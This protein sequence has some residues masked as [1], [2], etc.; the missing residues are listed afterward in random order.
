VNQRLFKR[1]ESGDQEKGS[2]REGSDIREGGSCERGKRL[3]LTE[4]G[5]EGGD[6]CRIV[7]GGEKSSVEGVP[8]NL[9]SCVGASKK[10]GR[11]PSWK[12]KKI[13]IVNRGVGR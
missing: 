3:F 12:E 11:K 9:Y 2:H 10:K 4:G 7:G 1:G 13:Y 8:H 5:K 6:Q